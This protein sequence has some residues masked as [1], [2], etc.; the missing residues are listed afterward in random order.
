[1]ALKAL[2][3][4]SDQLFL[5][6]LVPLLGP[7]EGDCGEDEKAWA[8]ARQ[9]TEADNRRVSQLYS[10][11]TVRYVGPVAEETT[12]VNAL[13]EWALQ[14]FL[15][16]TGVGNVTDAAGESL[17]NFKRG[18]NYDVLDMTLVEFQEAYGSLHPLITRA[19]RYVVWEINPI[20]DLR[21]TETPDE[22][23]EVPEDDENVGEE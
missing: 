18:D 10:A 22:A 13:D 14:V 21:P 12:D 1:M 4:Q 17:F 3:I 15:C 9:A 2:P 23:E 16:L 5:Q 11:R 20:W 8:T 19:L 7:M 6:N